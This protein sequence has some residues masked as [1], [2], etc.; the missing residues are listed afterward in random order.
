M[1][2]QIHEIKE[3][4]YPPETTEITYPYSVKIEQSARGIS[5]HV[6]SK[7]QET[8]VKKA[9]EMYVNTRNELKEIGQKVAVE[10]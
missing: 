5:V 7:G 4:E 10:E 2:Q 6:Y 3:A 9:I 1:N 8:A